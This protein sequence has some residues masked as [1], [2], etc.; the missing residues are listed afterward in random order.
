MPT[1][2]CGKKYERSKDDVTD[3]GTFLG[4]RGLEEEETACRRA[5]S[6]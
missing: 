1:P 4:V 2:V 3:D 5:A 6:K